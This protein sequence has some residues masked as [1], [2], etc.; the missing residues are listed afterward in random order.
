MSPGSSFSQAAPASGG[1]HA[2]PVQANQRIGVPKIAVWCGIATVLLYFVRG[3]VLPWLLHIPASLLVLANILVLVVAAC[4]AVFSVGQWRFSWVLVLLTFA[5]GL[6]QAEQFNNS[7]LRFAGL[8]ALIMGV[9]PLVVN[10]ATVAL[11]A[12]A[13]HF[14]VQGLP[15]VSGIFVVWYALR[16][17]NFGAGFFSGFMN[18]CMLAGPL[19]GMGGAI[20][21]ARAFDSRSWKW[22]L[23]ASLSI[24]PALASGSRVATLATAVTYCF[25][26]IRRKPALGVLGGLFLAGAIVAFITQPETS[27][28]SSSMT[29]A[30]VSKG[31]VNTRAE[32]WASRINEFKSSPLFGIGVAMGTGGGTSEEAGGNIRVEPGSSYLAILAMTGSF[33]TLA[34]CVA[35]G[36][37]L[38][39]FVRLKATGVDL[40]II[41]AMGVFLAVHGVAEGWVLAFGSPLAFLFWLWLG[42]LGDVADQ[43]V[44]ARIKPRGRAVPMWPRSILTQAENTK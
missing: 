25:I 20:A 38:A 13:W 39:N 18:Q 36:L 2:R 16:L 31:T 32:L 27:A 22:G 10:P 15:W 28:D 29:G 43:P 23:L 42:N 34:F 41:S 9:G 30:L 8:A 44:R 3:T 37:L 11:R 40:Q 35:L 7:A 6:S 26:I 24:I 33:G 4:L 14:V 21:L 5:A 19:A 17:P 12:A 1:P